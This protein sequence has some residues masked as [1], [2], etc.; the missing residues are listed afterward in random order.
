MAP[1]LRKVLSDMDKARIEDRIVSMSHGAISRSLSIPR[2]TVSNFIARLKNRGTHANLE[3]PGR[4]RITTTAQNKRIIAAAETHT[5]VPLAE[6][7]SITNVDVSKSTIRQRLH[8]VRIR[9]WRAV[10]RLLL[11]EQHAATRLKWAQEHQHKTREDWAKIAWSDEAAIQ[12]DSA[13]QQV[14][15]FRWQTKKEKYAPKNI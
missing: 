11:Q 13:H 5:H 15:V 8:E 12:K 4:P 9:K 14:W 1:T 2:R 7:R 3:H 10:K 6:L